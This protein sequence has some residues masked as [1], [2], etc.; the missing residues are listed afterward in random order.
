MQRQILWLQYSF[1]FEFKECKRISLQQLPIAKQFERKADEE[2]S[3]Q[4]KKRK[5]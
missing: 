5:K 3:I 2:Y 4:Q 1:Q